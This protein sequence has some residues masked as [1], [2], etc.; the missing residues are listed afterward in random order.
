MS[1]QC[2][3]LVPICQRTAGQAYLHDVVI[4][5]RD[6]R[7]AFAHLKSRAVRGGGHLQKLSKRHCKS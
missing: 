7:P 1:I 2:E 4:K 6:F 3:F 5:V